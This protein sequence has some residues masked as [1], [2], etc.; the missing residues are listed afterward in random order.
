MGYTKGK[1]SIELTK[2]GDF[3]IISTEDDLFPHFGASEKHSLITDIPGATDNTE[4]NAHLISAAP[5]MYEAL[6]LLVERMGEIQNQY[7][8]TLELPRV[9]AEKALAKADGRTE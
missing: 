2:H 1:W 6:K 3:L 8:I 4:A 7:P 9:W 5:D